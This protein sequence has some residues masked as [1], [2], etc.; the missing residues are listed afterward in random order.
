MSTGWRLSSDPRHKRVHAF[1][2]TLDTLT[3]IAHTINFLRFLWCGQYPTLTY[4]ALGCEMESIDSSS[5]S[6]GLNG[7]QI[8]VK[9]RQILIGLFM[10]YMHY[11]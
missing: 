8:G 7:V 5:R 6:E 1:I 4:R 2:D 10:V 9:Q 3:K 11:Y